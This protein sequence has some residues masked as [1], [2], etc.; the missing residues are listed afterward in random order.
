MSRAAPPSVSELQSIFDA[1]IQ[2][3][4]EGMP[5]DTGLDALTTNAIERVW[6][7]GPDAPQALITAARHE[8]AMQLDGSHAREGDAQHR[9][10]FA[11]TLEHHQQT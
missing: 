9:A 6:A 2:G 4:D 10:Q 11:A 8:L 3:S 5:S 1:L 7:A